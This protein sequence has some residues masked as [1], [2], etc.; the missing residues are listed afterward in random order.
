M[1]LY[2]RQER[3]KMMH[4]N[5]IDFENEKAGKLLQSK[6]WQCIALAKKGHSVALIAKLLKISYNTCARYLIEK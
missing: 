4:R 3:T 2:G 6:K 1:K 5:R